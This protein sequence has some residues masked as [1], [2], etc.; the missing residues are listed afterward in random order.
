MGMLIGDQIVP[1][2]KRWFLGTTTNNHGITARFINDEEAA[3]IMEGQKH[4]IQTL[5]PRS[6]YVDDEK[7]AEITMWNLAT[8]RVDFQVLCDFEFEEENNLFAM[9]IIA[10]NAN[11]ADRL[12]RRFFDESV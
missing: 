11:D 6:E 1:Q 9:Y 10:R 4:C 12:H 5:L 2:Y 8:S 3:V 7:N